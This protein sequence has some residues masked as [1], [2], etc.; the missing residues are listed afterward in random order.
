MEVKFLGDVIAEYLK[1]NKMSQE[2]F[3]VKVGVT[4]RAI[5]WYIEGLRVPTG[6]VLARI[7]K[8]TNTDIRSINI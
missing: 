8:E 5:R 4:G 6:N 2:E 1:A 7:C 3:A